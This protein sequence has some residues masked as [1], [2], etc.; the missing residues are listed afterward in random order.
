MLPITPTTDW[1]VANSRRRTITPGDDEL[2]LS[3]INNNNNNNNLFSAL[4]DSYSNSDSDDGDDDNESTPT[5]TAP[6]S[7]ATPLLLN[8]GDHLVG[9]SERVIVDLSEYFLHTPIIDTPDRFI[10]FT[11]AINR[12]FNRINGIDDDDS[13]SSI[14]PLS[15][16]DRTDDTA[17]TSSLSLCDSMGQDTLPSIDDYLPK[18]Y[19]T[20]AK[21][22]FNFADAVV[23][24]EEL[25]NALAAC[26]HTTRDAGHAYMVDT[27]KRHCERYG[28]TTALLPPPAM[29]VSIPDGNSSGEWRR[30]DVL[31]KIY[32]RE[33]HWNAEALQATVR[34]FPSAMKEKKN[35]YGTLPL[36]YTVRQA[37]N[38]IES[39]VSDRVKKQ[40]AY[41]D[42]MSSIT[43]RAYVPSS[44]GPVVYLKA[45]EHDKHC[46]DI[47]SGSSTSNFEY[48]W[49]T[50]IINCQTKIRGSG[51]HNNTY[52]RMIE[53]KWELDVDS[54]GRWERFKTLYIEELQKL[55]DDDI[56]TNQV[57]MKAQQALEARVNAFESK[58]ESD[59][60]TLNN[61][62]L[63]LETA[64]QASGVPSVVETDGTGTLSGSIA[65]TAASG[66]ASPTV[67]TDLLREMRAL[68]SE[69]H[70]I[71]NKSSGRPPPPPPSPGGGGGGRGDATS[72]G[73]KVW[74]QWQ[75]WC[76][77]C[78]C[79]LQHDSKDCTNPRKRKEGHKDEATYANPMGGNI[80]R[81]GLW[82]RWCQ[83]GTNRPFD[84]PE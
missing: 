32:E 81:N 78:G 43:A 27:A 37:L 75:Y 3:G 84:K 38:F 34:R 15:N 21:S 4:E 20:A 67:L 70:S 35:D 41:I 51:R 68:K 65:G 66:M 14:P 83:P 1:I 44:D 29:K 11:E 49:E 18:E 79:N 73:I 60:Q 12:D 26:Q 48:S 5:V 59:V 82:H 33:I 58:Y 80:A 7:I 62:Q 17:S 36:N 39:K 19:Q 13:N 8:P 45:M 55:T 10:A 30:Y 54:N 72:S 71:K 40:K 25:G 52:L 76:H 50:L 46:I 56:G 47:L 6:G 23:F 28:D 63:H 57:A 24:R 61:N 77:S 2:S 69:L 42:L 22:N 53:D 16:Q 31:K 74:R 64:F 9:T